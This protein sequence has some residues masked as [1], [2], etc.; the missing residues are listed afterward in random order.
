[1]S[2]QLQT[3]GCLTFREEVLVLVE[4]EQV[5][6]NFLGRMPKFSTEFEEIISR[7]N[8]I[9]KTKIMFWSVP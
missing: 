9:S 5:W 1:M 6:G 4:L 3:P 2:G 8:G 7:A